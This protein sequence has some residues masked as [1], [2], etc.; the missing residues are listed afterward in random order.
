MS[1]QKY[2]IFQEA[3][4]TRVLEC[5]CRQGEFSNGQLTEN[6]RLKRDVIERYY[7]KEI[8]NLYESSKD[9]TLL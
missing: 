3:S 6:G 7:Q 5:F 9:L 1:V 2:K 4:A 8:N